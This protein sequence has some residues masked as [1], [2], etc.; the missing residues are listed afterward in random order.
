MLYMYW[1]RYSIKLPPVSY[2]DETNR[3]ESGTF[4]GRKPLNKRHIFIFFPEAASPKSISFV[5][6][7]LSIYISI[8]QN[9]G[10]VGYLGRW[11]RCGGRDGV[12][13][14]SSSSPDHPSPSPPPQ[15]RERD[16]GDAASS[17]SPPPSAARERRPAPS[18][19]TDATH[20]RFTRAYHFVLFNLMQLTQK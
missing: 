13:P 10:H 15:Q 6:P 19:G 16:W 8:K 3:Y 9:P 20:H 18:P 14:S 4:N 11:G 2:G 5:K 12:C 17:S 7:P 1:S